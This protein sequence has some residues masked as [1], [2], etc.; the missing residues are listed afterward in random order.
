VALELMAETAAAAR[1]EWHVTQVVDVRMFSGIVLEE[2]QREIVLR[3]EPAQASADG[4]EWRVRITDPRKKNRPLYEARVCLAAVLPPPPEA[5][6]VEPPAEAFPL[7]TREAYD[8]WLFHGP[9]FRVIQQLDR[10]D[11]PP[12]HPAP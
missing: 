11:A 3:A 5:P 6:D 8:R 7:S 10:L 4:G 1:P 12:T 9:R 2:N